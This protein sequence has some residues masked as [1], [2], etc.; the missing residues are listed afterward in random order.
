M[1]CTSTTFAVN[2]TL[3]VLLVLGITTSFTYIALVNAQSPQGVRI[4]ANGD[5]SPSTAPIQRTGNLYTLTANLQEPVTVERG[6]AVLDGA[7]NTL[8]GPGTDQNLFAVNITAS[9]VTIQNLRVSN[10]KTGVLGAF[11]NNTIANNWF[12]QNSES[13]A[14]YGNDYN[15]VGNDISNSQTAVYVNDRY[16]RP[17][18]DKL[19]IAQNTLTNNDIAFQIVTSNGTTITQNTVID[20]NLILTL[21]MLGSDADAA[22]I[23]LYYNNFLGNNKTLLIPTPPIFGS[24]GSLKPLSPAGQWDNGSVGNYWSNY[25]QVYPNAV[26]IDHT[27][28]GNTAYTMVYNTTYSIEYANDTEESGILVLG[29]A[30]DRYPLIA[31]I[32]FTAQPTSPTP[33]PTI[34]PSSA[35]PEIPNIAA[36]PVIT[37][38][39]LIA[40]VVCR[41]KSVHMAR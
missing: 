39:A 6:N 20:N 5:I 18:G 3:V 38:V 15:I 35:I 24:A 14:I 40:L 1:R 32:S 16:A 9:N 29:T 31:P 4:D 26:E 37:A 34:A 41:K 8:L 10:W 30:A 28:I 17:Q 19:L 22:H 7:N 23:Y 33:S 13:I 11:D 27:G 12:T 36:I 25:L 21:G 2:V